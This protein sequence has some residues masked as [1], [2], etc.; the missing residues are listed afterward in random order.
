MPRRSFI[1]TVTNSD[2]AILDARFDKG[3]GC[4]RGA[5]FGLQGV[6]RIFARLEGFS[7]D[8]GVDLVAG[9][10]SC[11][12]PDNF[13][14]HSNR[15]TSFDQID[16]AVQ[17][18]HE[19]GDIA[20]VIGGDHAI[21]Y[22]DVRGIAPYIDGKVGIIRC[23]RHIDTLARDVDARRHTCPRCHAT[24]I[25]NA[26]PTS[27]MQVGIGCRI[28]NR[29]GVRVA[30]ERDITVISI[31]DVDE[32]NIDAVVDVALECAWEGA[33]AVFMSFAIEVCDPAC[34]PGP[35][36]SEPGG[37]SAREA[38]RAA[39]RVARDGLRGMEL[40]ESRPATAPTS[41]RSRAREHPR[42]ARHAG[43]E[44][45]ARLAPQSGPDRPARARRNRPRPDARRHPRRRGPSLPA[46][47]QGSIARAVLPSGP[48]ESPVPCRERPAH[49]AAQRIDHPPSTVMHWPVM[50]PASPE[51]R[52]P[53][54]AATSSGSPRRL[55]D[56]H[57]RSLR[58]TAPGSP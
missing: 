22:P 41:P 8:M 46:G 31:N 24:D 49:P 40:V 20:V 13:C 19:S 12:A 36:R 42:C 29:G 32:R 47:K 38:L 11:D 53:A 57:S 4:R 35:G 10:K 2:A 15:A 17:H 28:G 51:A 56:W 44:R 9:A 16:L 7:S 23:D 30:R 5:R 18:L 27:L 39:R 34:A 54:S 33:R 45:Q 37:L 3:T 43:A 55:T 50:K 1:R 14:V 58:S 6:R 21:G 25:P 52:K 26:P 48:R